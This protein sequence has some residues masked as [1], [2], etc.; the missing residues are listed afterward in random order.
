MAHAAYSPDV[1]DERRQGGAVSD[2]LVERARHGDSDAFVALVEVRQAAM[3]RVATAILGSG[4]D[5]S[6]AIQEA[7]MEAWRNLP[8]LRSPSAFDPWLERILVNRCRLTIRRR[9]RR[10][11]RE[12]PIDPDASAPGNV[13]AGLD[14]GLEGVVDRE[15]FDRAFDELSPDD[16]AILVLHHLEERPLAAI[17]A[18]LA[19]P[20][21]TAKSRLFHARRRLELAIRA[22]GDE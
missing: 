3:A 9:S 5:A 14:E 10:R 2:Q 7:L 11:L 15:V 8:H 19:I 1:N 22:E 20:V 21:G 18:A 16:R 13:P 6:D 17:A 12:I 4:P